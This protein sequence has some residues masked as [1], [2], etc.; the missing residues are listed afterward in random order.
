MEAFFQT[1]FDFQ[2]I[3]DNFGYVLDGFW[4]TIQLSIVGGILSLIWGLILAVLRQLPGRALAPVRGIVI[5]YIDALRGVPL[6]L[7]IFLISG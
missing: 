6:L 3:E 5:A 2:I 1:Y 4:Y 7:V